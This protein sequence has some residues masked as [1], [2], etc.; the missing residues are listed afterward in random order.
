GFVI[1]V[2]SILPMSPVSLS[3]FQYRKLIFRHGVVGV[4]RFQYNGWELGMMRRIGEMLSLQCESRPVNIPGAGL[5]GVFTLHKIA[6][7]KLHA[8]FLGVHIHHYSGQ[9]TDDM[10]GI[11]HTVRL[12]PVEYKIVIVSAT[13][14]ELGMVRVNSFSDCMLEGKIKRSICDIA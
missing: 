12:K 4:P 9:V 14:F 6:A 11:I 8:R 2:I 3:G 10:C 5:E 7:I 13:V 1:R